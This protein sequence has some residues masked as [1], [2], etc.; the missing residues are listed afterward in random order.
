[1]K[2]NGKNTLSRRSQAN[3]VLMGLEEK[4]FHIFLATKPNIKSVEFVETQDKEQ[5]S[6]QWEFIK[7][8]KEML[9][10]FDISVTTLFQKEKKLSRNRGLGLEL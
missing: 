3:L 6:A 10:S 1:L 2:T 4:A 8:Q 7:Q 5:N 9:K